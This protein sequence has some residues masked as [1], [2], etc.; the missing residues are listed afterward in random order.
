MTAQGIQAID[1]ESVH[2]I[3]SGQVVLDLSSA[4]KELVENSIDAKA[5]TV[6]I[7]FKENGLEGLEVIDNGIGVDP[8]N[9]S[10]LALKHYTSK[11]TQ[12]KD[13]E[14]VSTF[15]FRGE[16]L[17]SLCALAK[18]V[19][20][21]AT[22]DQA[23]KGVRL[24]Y[25]HQGHL[26]SQTPVAR[27]MGT[28][29][30]LQDLFHSLPVRQRE[31]KRNIKRD[32]SKA[33]SVIQAYGIISTGVRVV[34]SNQPAKGS[35]MRVLSTNGSDSV[36]ENLANV[37][38]AKITTQVLPFEV[39]LESSDENQDNSD[40][41]HGTVTGFISKPEFGMG[42]QKSDRQYFYING[43]PC[44][45]PKMSKAFNEVYRN[46]IS[47]QY[48]FVVANFKISPDSYDVNVSPDKRTIFL[49]NEKQLSETIVSDLT[50]QLE[51]SRSTFD[52]NPLLSL[53]DRSTLGKQHTNN[54]NNNDD[55]DT[56]NSTSS[57]T[58]RRRTLTSSSD[59]TIQ[60]ASFAHTSG[61]AYRPSASTK[62]NGTTTKAVSKRQATSTL[63]NY[64]KRSKP[65]DINT[66][67]DDSNLEVETVTI[68]DMG[69]NGA[70]ET[71][72][73][74]DMEEDELDD[75]DD[76][77]DDDDEG[78]PSSD[79]T[80]IRNM[81]NSIDDCVLIDLELSHLGRRPALLQSA[82]H[83]D[84][85]MTALESSLKH[86]SLRT[87]DNELATAALNRVINKQDFSRIKVIGQFNL[88]FIVGLL[89][90][91]DLFIIDQHASD[92]KY[93]FETLQKTTQLKGQQL[94]RPQAIDMTASEELLAMDNLNIFKANG[95]NMKVDEDAEPTKRIS[96][97]SQP[98][99]ENTMLNKADI[100]ELIYLIR[101]RPGE[102]VR[103]SRIR[104]MF[105]SRACRKSYMIGDHLDMKQMLK[106][107]RHMGEIDQPWNCPHGRPTMRHLMTIGNLKK[108][109]N[110]LHRRSPSCRGSLFA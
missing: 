74:A 51:P 21:T 6:E 30:Q 109:A 68:T 66:D 94:I 41:S 3:C 59:A 75:D 67:T 48:P 88:G 78:L 89:D 52:V 28:T 84:A 54:D 57:N 103:C 58:S 69:R 63:M 106:I 61:S 101:E 33:L 5:T 110:I 14:K 11:I 98:F 40:T 23:P 7:I 42:R 36:R 8:S 22:K 32:Y 62:A 29:I 104:S 81:W 82:T 26:I 92:E 19:V 38:G 85:N 12:F 39:N 47:N 80:P 34:A 65:T 4:M 50:S 64:V 13:L 53:K 1:K 83:E 79:I 102:M 90:G 43:R 60:L 24:E 55:S 108:K 56:S 105:A 18:L 16:A 9:Y 71:S 70:V 87:D 100:S 37:F 25:D 73:I 45:L 17:S 2:R 35:K 91:H 99:S 95:F 20:V 10:S 97:L 46:F 31:F 49:H 76:D 44:L 86:A 96:V 107:V 27:S 15:G 77:D 72:S 93:N